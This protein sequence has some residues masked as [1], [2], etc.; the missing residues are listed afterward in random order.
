[1][2]YL[3][4]KISEE[5]ENEGTWAISYG[6]MITLLLSFFVIFFT[7]DFKAQKVESM[8][9]HLTFDL[10]VLNTETT[11][12]E[13]KKNVTIPEMDGLDLKVHPVGENLIITF[14]KKSFFESGSTKVRPEVVQTL[15]LF[16]QKYL[17]YAG[18]Y[19]LS[20]KGFTD[21]RRVLKLN[22]KYE[23]NLE[24]SVLRA[25]SVM[26]QFQKLGIPLNRM[27]IAGLGEMKQIEK[28]IPKASEL[29]EAEL[30]SLSRTIVLVIKPEREKW[31]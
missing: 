4:T 27:E 24:L 28:I 22:R 12:M 11:S 25:V 23:D 6:D 19:Q 8:N 2:K 20:I 30:N 9:R 13:V 21:K 31:L 15:S 14:G 18:Q 7:T 16:V 1:M 5:E 29:T 3:K 10:D 26:R 17:P